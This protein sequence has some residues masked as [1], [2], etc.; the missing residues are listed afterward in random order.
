[1]K[2]VVLESF[3]WEPFSKVLLSYPPLSAISREGREKG[4]Q[5]SVLACN[6]QAVTSRKFGKHWINCN[7]LLIPIF[8]ASLLKFAPECG[9]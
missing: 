5:E 3:I 9:S 7:T 1:M 6:I 8:V 2:A 4:Y